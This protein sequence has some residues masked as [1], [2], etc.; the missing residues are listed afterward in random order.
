MRSQTVAEMERTLREAVIGVAHRRQRIRRT[1]EMMSG[2]ALL[3]WA[4][5]L[6]LVDW[7]AWQIYQSP[8]L[9]TMASLAPFLVWEIVLSLTGAALIVSAMTRP[10]GTPLIIARVLANCLAALMLTTMALAAIIPP[11]SGSAPT[12]VVMAAAQVYAMLRSGLR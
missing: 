4:L 7:S 12:L 11:V 1:I 2:A 9:S 8:S 3:L 6:A 5:L 10:L